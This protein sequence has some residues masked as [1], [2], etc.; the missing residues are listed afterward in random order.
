MS[1]AFRSLKTIQ[2]AAALLKLHPQQRMGRMRLLK[3]LYIADRESLKE[4]GR[5]ITG[6]RPISLKL[7]PVLSGVY[8]LIKGT[9]LPTRQAEWDSWFRSEGYQIVLASDPGIGKLSRYEL[10]VLREIAE[11]FASKDDDDLCDYTHT[12][13]EWKDPGDSSE[14]ISLEAILEAVGCADMEAVR[15]NARLDLAATRAFGE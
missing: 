11:R 2:A 14:P 8:D 5:P 1:F 7:G 6:D 15:E 3:L 13:A 10:Q 9:G 12:F 4:K